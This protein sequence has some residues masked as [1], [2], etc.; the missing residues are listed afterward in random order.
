MDY[1]P[2]SEAE[3]RD[4]AAQALSHLP[5]VAQ[6][7]NLDANDVRNA[8]FHLNNIVTTY[9]SS[10]SQQNL[11]Q[12]SVA[13]KDQ[14]QEVGIPNLR[15]FFNNLKSRRDYNAGI[16]KILNIISQKSA[17]V[18]YDALKPEP[19]ISKIADGVKITYKKGV[20]TGAKIYCRRGNETEF[21]FVTMQD[22]NNYVDTRPNLNQAAAERREYYL[23]Y[24]RKGKNIGQQSDIVSVSI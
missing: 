9:D 12:Q 2:R 10:Q 5:Q 16:G 14:A 18:D 3:L 23:I 8:T 13:N 17:E 19:K 1:F 4:W 7:L 11:W 21:S 6:D 24:F 22:L 15:M 20:A